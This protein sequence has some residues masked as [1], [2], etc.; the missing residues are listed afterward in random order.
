MQEVNENQLQQHSYTS[1]TS[2]NFKD[3]YPI[4]KPYSPTQKEIISQQKKKNLPTSSSLSF[5]SGFSILERSAQKRLFVKASSFGTL[6]KLAYPLFLQNHRTI[7]HFL[8]I[9]TTTKATPGTQQTLN[10]MFLATLCTSRLP[11]LGTTS[12]LNL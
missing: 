12:F 5:S 1:C 10:I 7:S 6:Q 2:N 4:Y 9:F 8:P 3:F 11:I